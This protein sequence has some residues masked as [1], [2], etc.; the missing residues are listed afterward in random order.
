MKYF[1]S[2]LLSEIN[3]SM[4]FVKPYNI[5]SENLSQVESPTSIRDKINSQY[6]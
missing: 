4:N 6:I 2:F 5:L 3:F 1:I